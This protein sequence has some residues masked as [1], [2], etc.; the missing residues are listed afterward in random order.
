MHSRAAPSSDKSAATARV[1]RLSFD[2]Y[3]LDLSRGCLL[4]DNREV[5]L[6]PKTFAVLKFLVENSGRLVS[7][8]DIFAAVW[9]NLAVT[10]DTLVQSIGELRRELGDDGPRL[11]KT[12]P[13]RGYRFDASVTELAPGA[14]AT[15][16]VEPEPAAS[17]AEAKTPNDVPPSPPTLAVFSSRRWVPVAALSLVILLAVGALLLHRSDWQLPGSPH[18][19]GQISKP[20]EANARPAIAILPFV[21][22]SNDQGRDYFADGLTQDVINALGRFSALTVMSWNAVA[23]YKKKAASPDEVARSLGVRYQVEGSVLRTGDRVRVSAQLV[24]S[25]GQ[26][27]WSARFDEAMADLFAL[28]DKIT[29]HIV[30]VLATRVTQIEQR[31]ALAKPT[32]NLEAYEYVLRA[33]PA[34]QRP[35]RAEIVE[36]RALLR[37]AI[38]LDPN[39]A[40]AHSGLAETYLLATVM[41]WAESPSETLGRAAELANK[42]LTLDE[43]DVR[44]HIILGRIHIFHQRYEQAKAEMERAIAV[45]PNDGHG[46]AGRGNIL[47]WLGQTDAAVEALELARRIDP[48]LNVVDRNAL[49]LAYYLKGRYAEA[50]EEAELN[51]RRTEGANF[52]RVVLAA[53]YAQESRA[54]DVARVVAAV[55]RLDPAFDPQEFGSKF[56]SPSD[57]GHLRDGLRKA[58]LLAGEAGQRPKD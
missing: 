37:R 18:S 5:F 28:Q 41:G 31:R 1:T 49:S 45:N 27:L 52:T 17:H 55:H 42:A 20:A 3:V 39:Y 16:N 35:D 6:R 19:A 48:E 40:A 13:R 44:S 15:A 56:L 24:N 32:D 34:L 38:A 43:S 29:A 53:S 21:N 7:K 12:I 51:L 8:D 11:I 54:E 33:R 4:L 36:A 46:L 14:D 26:I 58:G 9:P 25:E 47:L 57:L 23:P 50:I 22:Q 2:R 10:D 30:G